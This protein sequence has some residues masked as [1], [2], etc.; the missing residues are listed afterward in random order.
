MPITATDNTL[1]TSGRRPVVVAVVNPD[2]A[3]VILAE[4]G[5]TFTIAQM[6]ASGAL[7]GRESA[8]ALA[9]QRGLVQ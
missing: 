3:A 8:T 6:I 1:L 5:M 2:R 7:A 9:K 4:R